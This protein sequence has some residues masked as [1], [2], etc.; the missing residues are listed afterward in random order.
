MWE[1][2]VALGIVEGLT[3]F[4]PVSSTGHLILFG[5]LLGFEGPVAASF[6]IFIQLGAILSVAVLYRERFKLLL[7]SSPGDGLSGFEGLTKLGVA[8]FPALLV[9][10]LLGKHIKALLF[11]PT[12]VAYALMVGG[13]VMLFVE[14]SKQPARTLTLGDISYG[15]ALAVGIAQCF[16]LWPGVS[17]AGATIIG[18]LLAGLER[19]I[20]AEFSFLIAVPMMCAATAYDLLKHGDE[21][22]PEMLP[23]FLLGSIV[24]FITAMLAIRAFMAV[25]GTWSFRPFGWYRIAV[26]VAALIVLK[27]AVPA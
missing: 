25:I 13:V 10:F 18:G 3:E 19:R 6:E 20:A 26:G 17:R 5:H 8:C 16:A 27:D 15:Q 22:P 9:G 1:I 4:L 24:A 7:F 11:F 14:R 2:I 12:P 23:H 21:I